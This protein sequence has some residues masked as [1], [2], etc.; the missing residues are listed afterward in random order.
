MSTCWNTGVYDAPH[1]RRLGGLFST[2]IVCEHFLFFLTIVYISLSHKVS[3]IA[4]SLGFG[5]GCD[6]GLFSVWCCWLWP[7][8]LRG[9]EGWLWRLGR[10]Q[11]CCVGR[12]N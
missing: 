6:G 2:G 12:F 3:S 11:A 8:D 9:V 1:D 5:G 10:Q 7:T 4:R